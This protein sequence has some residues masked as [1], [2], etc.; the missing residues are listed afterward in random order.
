VGTDYYAARHGEYTLND[1]LQELVFWSGAVS[2]GLL[3]DLP[4]RLGLLGLGAWVSFRTRTGRVVVA[5]TAVFVGLVAIFRYVDVPSLRTLFALT[6]PWGVD[7]RLLM[8]VP[9]FAAP[10]AGAGL[11]GLAR[12]LTSRSSG[13][14]TRQVG[15]PRIAKRAFVFGMAFGLA[16]VFL[17]AAK[18][19]LQT[20]GIVTYSADDAV[21]MGWLRQHAQPGEV[22]MND[23]AADAGIWAPYK[24]NVSIVLPRTKGVAPDGPELLLRAH[25]DSLDSRAD[26]RAAAC[27]LGV[28][29]VFRGEGNSPSEYREFPSLD[30]LRRISALEEIFSSGQAALFRTRLNCA[31]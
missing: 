28:R 13:S 20:G 16:S 17:V 5:L 19:S 1:P 4:I 31:A 22:L 18:F 11:V 14:S 26:V 7:G 10:L 23:G 24:G 25:L 3:V 21:V 8:T 15:W 6:L 2:S 30:A 27:S 29:Y 12:A 9:L